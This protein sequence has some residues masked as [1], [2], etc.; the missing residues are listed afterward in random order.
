[1]EG[2]AFFHWSMTPLT[3]ALRSVN[4]PF[5][6]KLAYDD[7]RDRL[8]SGLMDGSV[9]YLKYEEKKGMVIP[10]ITTHTGGVSDVGD[11]GC[12]KR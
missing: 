4:P 5:V 9:R 12:R 3:S 10:V 1:M 2:V 6:Y 11:S 8:Y 7:R